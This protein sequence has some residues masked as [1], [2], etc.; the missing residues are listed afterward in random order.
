MISYHVF[1]FT[2]GM[3][4][5]SISSLKA[6]VIPEETRAAIMT[7][8]RIPMNLGVGVIMWH[9]SD[10]HCLVFRDSYLF[11]GRS[12]VYF[13]NVCYLLIH[14]TFRG[15]CCF[16]QVQDQTSVPTTTR[17]IR[18]H[19]LFSHHSPLYIL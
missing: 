13:N 2:T 6:E 12:F 7:L 9:V 4:F 14:D 15:S 1:E 11:L 16:I 3:Y 19:Y 18:C 10:I 5:P 8:L 17:V